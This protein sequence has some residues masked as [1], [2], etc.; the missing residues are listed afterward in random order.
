MADTGIIRSI[1]GL[2]AEVTVKEQAR[3]ELTITQHPVE[4]GAAISD[5]LFKNPAML[6]VQIGWSAAK[7]DPTDLYQQLLTMQSSGELFE[8]QTGKRL[9]QNMAM[10]TLVQDT[11]QASENAL[12]VTI[13]L[14]E[15]MLVD[16]LETTMPPNANRSDPQSASGVAD[17]GTKSL[18]SADTDP[19]SN[20][21]TQP[22]D[23]QQDG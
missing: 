14:Q 17:T 15:L 18:R 10:R 16:T 8:V 23:D 4:R 11:D 6:M 21:N 20:T 2:T 22:G 9:Y 19:A 5:H 1:G 13:Q 12:N 7:G 3:D